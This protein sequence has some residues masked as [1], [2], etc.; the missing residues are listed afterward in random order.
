M[1]ILLMVVLFVTPLR[2]VENFQFCFLSQQAEIFSDYSNSNF[3]QKIYSRKGKIYPETR[4]LN[5]F[6]INLNFRIFLNHRYVAGLDP[7]IRKILVDLPV[8]AMTLRDFLNHVGDFFK[9]NIRY[10]DN[11]LP[12]DP[13]SVLVN[14]RANCIGYSNLFSVLLKSV[15]IRN[16]F[17]KGFYLEKLKRNHWMPVPHRW[18]E[19]TLSNG[20]KFF[21]DPQYQDFSANYVVIKDGI[22]FS[23]IKKFKVVLIKT[24]REIINR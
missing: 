20:F 15:G 23:N 6:D 8:H 1:K 19:I 13:L 24:T 4:G 7:E 14:G 17:V 5:F 3:S 21:Y 18:I 11:D 2:Q 12:Q 16:R 10:Q 9:R 22:D